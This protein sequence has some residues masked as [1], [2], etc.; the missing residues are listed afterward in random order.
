MMKWNLCHFAVDFV[1][2]VK[3]PPRLPPDDEGMMLETNYQGS[4]QWNP[5]SVESEGRK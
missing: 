3:E 2:K 5:G 1:K 4:P